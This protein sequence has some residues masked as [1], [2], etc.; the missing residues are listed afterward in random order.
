[1][2]SLSFQNYTGI[3]FYRTSKE[4]EKSV[5]SRNGLKLHCLTEEKEMTFGSS[6]LEEGKNEGFHSLVKSAIE[7]LAWPLFIS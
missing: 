5:S 3:L 6:Y 4:N 7:L 1:M 2:N